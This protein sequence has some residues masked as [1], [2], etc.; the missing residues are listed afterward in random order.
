MKPRKNV[1]KTY[2][3]SFKSGF[4]VLKP[5]KNLKK[6]DFKTIPLVF[7]RFF[8]GFKTQKPDIIRLF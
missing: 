6:P 1:K 5:R 4:R 3:V 2:K 7:I 8:L